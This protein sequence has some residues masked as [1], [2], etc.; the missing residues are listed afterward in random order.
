MAV[1]E[2]ALVGAYLTCIFNIYHS[3]FH[4]IMLQLV[5]DLC[6]LVRLDKLVACVPCQSLSVTIGSSSSG[7]LSCYCLYL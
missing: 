1:T 7:L 5:L 4:S 2:R 6:Y 3:L